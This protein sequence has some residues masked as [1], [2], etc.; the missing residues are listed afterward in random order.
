MINKV[1]LFVTCLSEQFFTPTLKNLVSILERLGIE[2]EFPD[3]QTCC[4]QPFYNNGFQNQAKEVAIEW[5][6]TFSKSSS[7]IISPSGSCVATI[8]NHYP[9]LFSQNSPE[10]K[11]AVELS[12]RTYEFSEFLVRKL[13]IINLGSFFPHKVTYHASCHL[14]RELRLQKEPKQLLK[15]VNG[16]DFI[17]LNEEE[18]CCGFGGSLSILYPGVSKALMDQKIKNII[19]CNVEYVV[20]SEAGCLMNISG[21][22]KRAGSKIK[23]IHLIDVL[24][25]QE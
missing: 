9:G 13:G 10:Y 8:R 20:I 16:L 7:P 14:L 22:L 17:K 6:K 19:N 5:I 25:N 15:E 1:Q 23:A 3:K 24:A 12:E 11:L 4:G 21:G 18:T 2:V